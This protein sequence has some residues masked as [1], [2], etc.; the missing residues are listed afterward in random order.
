MVAENTKKVRNR[1]T[2]EIIRFFI[3]AG[4]IILLNVLATQVFFRWDLTEDKRYSISPATKK[5]LENLD[6]VVYV[7]VYLEGEFPAGFKRLQSSIK[8]KLDEFRIYSGQN[9]QYKF[10]DPSASPDQKARNEFYLQLA[11]KGLQPT[12][13][14]AMEGDKRVE[15][16]I[17]PGAVISYRGKEIP[18]LLLKGNQAASPEQ[19]LNQSVEGVEYELA[20]AI[21]KLTIKKRKKIGFL[22]GHGE[23]NVLE[24][25]SLMNALSEYY[26]VDRVDIT[27][28]NTLEGFDAIVL[29]RPTERFGEPDKF[30]I[31]QY[32]VKGGNVFLLYDPMNISLDSIGEKGTF[33]FP[34]NTNL[35]D[36][37]FRFGFRMNNDMI[38]DLSSGFIPMVVGFVGNQPQTEMTPW[39]YFPLVNNFSKHPITK[40]LDAVYTKFVSTIDTVKAPGIRKTPLMFTSRYARILPAPVRVNFNEARLDVNPR[41]FTKGPL[42]VAYMLE[43]SF[44][45]LYKNRLAPE[46]QQQVGFVEFGKPGKLVIVSDGDLI[47]NDVNKKTNTPLELGYDRFAGVKFGNKEFAMNAL[48][49]MLDESGLIAVRTKE[50]VLRPL[51]KVKLK[52]ERTR[53]QM[54]NIVLPLVLLALYGIVR[55]YLRK[56]KYAR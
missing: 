34:H 56:R 40:N 9:I 39:R 1:K 52:E 53:W 6:D 22:E 3:L 42:P 55:F 5:L 14:N 36:L 24:T 4:I 21:R 30:K 16:I 51:D 31:D 17:F 15:K 49:Y 38:Q 25:S 37:F 47:R 13:L 10:V 46:K 11:K 19:R 18:V 23:L 45:S 43:G 48:D 35:D 54:I 7:E 44:R 33:S 32:L 50:I 41:V 27:Q 2:H 28:R 12:N 20:S 29:A 26:D 8:E